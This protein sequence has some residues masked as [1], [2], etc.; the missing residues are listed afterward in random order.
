VLRPGGRLGIS[1]VI[2]DDDSA[3]ARR[4][5]AARR[6]GCVA[7]VLTIGVYQSMLTAAGLVRVSVSPTADHG[8]GVHSAIVQA[9]KPAAAD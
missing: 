7:G 2:A 4:L 9:A 5:Q 3:P 6:V 8:D 1:D